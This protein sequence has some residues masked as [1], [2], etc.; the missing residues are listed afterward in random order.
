MHSA[1]GL[2]AGVFRRPARPV[3]GQLFLNPNSSKPSRANVQT[4]IRSHLPTAAS[5]S[6]MSATCATF[7]EPRA[8]PTG[9]S[10]RS[11]TID[12]WRSSRAPDRPIL[13]AA[14]RADL[15]L[16]RARCSLRR[17]VRRCD[18]RAVAGA[19][20]PHVHCKGTD[21]TVD[22]VPERD[23]VRAYG[24][25]TAIVGD[26]RTHATRDLL[27]ESPG[28]CRPMTDDV[29]LATGDCRDPRLARSSRRA[30]RHRPRDTGGGG[31]SPR[32]PVRAHRLARRREAQTDPRPRAGH[33]PASRRERSRRRWRRLS[34]RG[35]I[36]D[37][38]RTRYDATIDLQGLIKSGSSHA[39]PARQRRRIRSPVP[40]RAAG[41]HALHR[42]P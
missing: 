3:V 19:A 28:H 1:F 9:S 12:R 41:A 20:R 34:D 11:T 32:V 31:A 10:S 16:R 18:R 22:T 33:R 27:R 5:I 23:V 38:R 15:R 8:K 25:R 2:Q 40:E 7:R 6:C 39:A 36:R 24:G 42:R 21:Y 14:D 26:L 35:T 17:R 30:G 13:A 37:L 29:W 4:D